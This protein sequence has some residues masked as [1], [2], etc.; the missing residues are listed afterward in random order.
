MSL[1]NIIFS[2]Q[3]LKNLYFCFGS[4]YKLIYRHGRRKGHT[5]QSQ[6]RYSNR[7]EFLLCSRQKQG[8]GS[9]RWSNE[10]KSTNMSKRVANHMHNFCSRTE[11]QFLRKEMTNQLEECIKA[12]N[13]FCQSRDLKETPSW[14]YLSRYKAVRGHKSAR[15]T[16]S[17]FPSKT[18]Y[19]GW[20]YLSKK[21]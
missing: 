21:K 17:V 1:L 19:R 9:D 11:L 5:S 15:V 8:S 10:K 7:I 6:C 16:L 20:V 2:P 14:S 3:V 13:L 4:R 18:F 12:N